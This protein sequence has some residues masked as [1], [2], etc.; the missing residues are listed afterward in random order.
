M[1]CNAAT[2]PL[3]TTSPASGSAITPSHNTEEGNQRGAS[4]C[5]PGGLPDDGQAPPTSVRLH[6]MG[7]RGRTLCR[8][9]GRPFSNLNRQ[10]CV[11]DWVTCLDCRA[12][13][14]AGA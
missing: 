7:R 1:H 12:L 11:R 5:A 14:E 4:Q 10:T 13:L 2:D 9:P 3:P 6:F 8:A